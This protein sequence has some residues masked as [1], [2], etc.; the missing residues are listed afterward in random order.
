MRLFLLFFS[1]RRSFLLE[2]S[3]DRGISQKV[4]GFRTVHTIRSQDFSSSNQKRGVFIGWIVVLVVVAGL[5]GAKT[6]AISFPAL[7]AF[8]VGSEIARGK[9]PRILSNKSTELL[10]LAAF[11]A[12]VMLSLLWAPIVENAAT[13]L[14]IMAV[15]AALALACKQAIGGETDANIVRLSEGLWIA[16][17]VGVLYLAADLIT[18]GGT[19]GLRSLVGL[20]KL[21]TMGAAEVTRAITPVTMLL[22]PSI[23]CV[24]RGIRK[25]LAVY[26]ALGLV[27]V[28]TFTV[29]ISPHE[30]SKLAVAVWLLTIGIGYFSPKW[31]GRLIIVGW[32]TV[33]ILV[34]P[35]AFAAHKL[36]LQHAAWM[37][38]SASQRILIWHEYAE[39][40]VE[41]P[42]IGHGLDM[43][44]VLRPEIKGLVTLPYDAK[45]LE[46][47]QNLEPFYGVH[48]HNAYLQIWFEIGGI[49]AVLFMTV[50]LTILSQIADQA[51][52]MQ[53]WLYATFSSVA[54]ILFS[55]YGL[56][57]IWLLGL[58]AF[59]VFACTIA[60]RQ[61]QVAASQP[62][63]I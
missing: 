28:S 1:K 2:D 21:M 44:H 19:G 20:Q 53:P 12:Y 51:R 36:D 26:L 37:Q 29:S 25:P 13:K 54:C 52:S 60:I 56:W 16:Y 35:L 9:R 61:D 5:V 14:V 15:F 10:P 23:V 8:V 34:V 57:Q 7:A 58:L 45:H 48:P 33:C 50:G 11:F 27:A 59:V 32:V 43:S 46:P 6:W 42:I 3:S 63:P 31:V 39:R 30:T 55:S 18:T 62:N 40:I 41:A 49:G 38:L 17:F 22:G 47:P 24:L 4:G